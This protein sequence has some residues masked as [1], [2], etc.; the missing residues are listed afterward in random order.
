M[1]VYKIIKRPVITEKVINQLEKE[2]KLVFIVANKATKAV[3]KEA[4]E[5]LY[6]V[7]VERINT[8]NALNGDKRA[9]VRLA[10][11]S[12]ASDVAS[13]LGVI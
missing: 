7:K 10:K 12:K 5:S 11:E 1:S 3:I 13:K 2:N 4:V 8:K 9:Y 6:S